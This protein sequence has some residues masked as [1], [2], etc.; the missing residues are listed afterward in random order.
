SGYFP[1]AK[2]TQ[3]FWEKLINGED[4]I[5]RFTDEELQAEGEDPSLLQKT[6][7]VRA[8]GT[9]DYPESFDAGFF[10]ISP[11]EAMTID[12]QQRIFLELC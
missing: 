1:K 2:N 3:E 8:K 12:P 6:N 10:G 11:A 4:C 9:I 7:Y 5:T